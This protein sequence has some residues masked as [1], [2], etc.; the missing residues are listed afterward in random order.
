MSCHVSH[1]YSATDSSA[2]SGLF[3]IWLSAALYLVPVHAD[4][5]PSPYRGSSFLDHYEH[6]TML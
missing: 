3:V 6:Y 4:S 1:S 5:E 2:L